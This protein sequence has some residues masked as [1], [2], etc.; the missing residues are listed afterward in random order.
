MSHWP[1]PEF[2]LSLALLDMN[3]RRFKRPPFI[4]IEEK[5]EA[6]GA[7][8]GWH[9]PLILPNAPETTL[10]YDRRPA[11]RSCAVSLTGSHCRTVA[12]RRAAAISPQWTSSFLTNSGRFGRRRGRLRARNGCRRRRGGTSAR[13]SRSRRCGGRRR[14]ALPAIYVGED[15]G[16]SGLGRLDAAIIFEELAAACVVDRGLSVD[17]QHGGM[18]DRPLRQRASSA[19][20]FCRSWPRMAHFASYCLTEPGS[21]SD[22]AALAT[23]AMRDG[24]HYVLNGTKAFISGGGVERHLCRDGAHRRRRGRRAS[25]ASSSR[26]GRPASPSARRRRK[27]GWNTPADRDGDLRGLPRAGRQPARRRRA[28]ASRSR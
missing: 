3:M 4:G 27:L 16:G 18:D 23:R 21:G 8:D 28:T 15:F 9:Q 22:A 10:G 5:S 11:Q 20:G 13:N 26:R 14:W 7:K 2:C 25:P 17:P 19:R 1:K 6:A 12:A 24:D